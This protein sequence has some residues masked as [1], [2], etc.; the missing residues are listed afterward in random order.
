MMGLVLRDLDC[1]TVTVATSVEAYEVARQQALDRIVVDY[2]LPDAE[3]AVLIQRLR[4]AQGTETPVAIVTSNPK[5]VLDP[6]AEII[7]RPFSPDS[8]IERL[9]PLVNESTP[10]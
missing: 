2:D 1:E 9:R 3:P 4:S 7:L 10:A 5:V 8:L 6:G